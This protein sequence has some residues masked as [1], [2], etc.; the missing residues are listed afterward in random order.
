M[1]SVGRATRLATVL[2]GVAIIAGACSSAATPTP[3]KAP[4][5]APTQKAYTI[6]SMLWNSSIPFYSNFVKGQQDTA[7]QLGVTL[8]LQSGDGQ[9]EK[10][11][12]T[13][14]QF[15]AKK[16][17]LI[18]VTPSDA[19][20]IVPVIKEANA[21]GIPVIAA[22]N[23]VGE[24]AQLVTF[25]GA[26]D[27]QFGQKQGE[28]LVKAVG[29]NANVGYIMGK[30]GTSAQLLRKQGLDDYLK[31]HAGIKLIESQS[32]D[33]DNAKA[34]A[35]A[36]D[37]LNKYPKGKIDAIIDQGPEGATAAKW[38]FDNGRTDVKFLMGDYPKDVRD[39]IVAGYIFGSV[40][41]DPLPQGVEAVKA[42]VNWLNGLKDKVPQPNYYLDLPIV[43]KDNVEQFPPAW[44]G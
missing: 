38:A 42:A 7:K 5:Q 25:V 6:G 34:L 8:D 4:S 35:L 26:D 23:K 12:A 16:V 1:R 37:W 11:I 39:G 10:E 28:L 13:I 31:D 15:I 24:G 40:D 17:D 18:I 33:W 19:Q 32:A 30:L 22:N 43:T 20:G 2:A 3:S 29:E 44:G 9:L 41:Q 36:Q 27:Y 21:A 14:Q